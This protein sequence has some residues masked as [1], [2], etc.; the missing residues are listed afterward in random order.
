MANKQTSTSLPVVVLRIVMSLG[1][2]VPFTTLLPGQI[3]SGAAYTIV[4]QFSGKALDDTNA[5]TANGTQMQQWACNGQTQQNWV[6]TAVGGGYYTIVNQLSGKALDDT[7]ASRS[8]GTIMQQWAPNGQQQQ[9]WMLNRVGGRYYTVVN[10]LSG[11]ALDDTNASRS[12]GTLLQQWD[13]NGQQQQ[14]W[15]IIPAGSCGFSILVDTNQMNRYE[16]TSGALLA[17]DGVWAVV[18]NSCSG[19]GGI[20]DPIT[21]P[22]AV[23]PQALQNLNAASWAMTEEGYNNLFIPPANFSL[24]SQ[25]LQS[26]G[27]L[28]S[29]SMVYHECGNCPNDTVLTTQE[30]DTAAAAI[31]TGVVVLSR[32][33]TPGDPRTDYTRQAL[34]DPNCSGVAF[35][36]NPHLVPNLNLIQGIQDTLSAGKKSYLLVPPDVNASYPSYI[37]SVMQYL[38][39]GPQLASP[40]LYLVLA[41]YDRQNNG[42]GFLQADFGDRSIQ[43][44]DNWLKSY[45]RNT[46]GR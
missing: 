31:G 40:D 21:N 25:Y 4:N 6:L 9:N 3:Q 28:R 33:Y 35:E 18:V 23:W 39:Q 45:R 7:N 16:A 11:K 12:N 19:C 42:E 32:T 44:A 13:R 22:S 17:A 41:N 43:S 34:A 46:F 38:S 24:V 5:S 36:V 26:V 37:G 10:Q 15:M 14:N 20:T 2:V 27:L 30:I 29:T 8:N 1:V